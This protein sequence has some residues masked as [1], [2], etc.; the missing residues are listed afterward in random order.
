MFRSSTSSKKTC[1]SCCRKRFGASSQRVP[2]RSRPATRR[3]IPRIRLVE[4]IGCPRPELHSWGGKRS[5][6]L[7]VTSPPRLVHGR[8]QP[9]Q[10]SARRRRPSRQ[11]AQPV[12]QSRKRSTGDS[13]RFIAWR[14]QELREEELGPQVARSQELREEELGEEE[15]SQ[16][17]F[18][19]EVVGEEV[20]RSQEP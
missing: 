15:L 5:R 20:R 3:A 1:A 11:Q 9:P 17:E 6:W 10:P 7:L 18:R 16:E 19:E 14:P 8:P 13:P 2:E 4:P 12:P